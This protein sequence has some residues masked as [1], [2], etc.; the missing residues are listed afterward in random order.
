MHVGVHKQYCQHISLYVLQRTRK[1]L[2][3][4]TSQLS[5]SLKDP[6]EDTRTSSQSLPSPG[7]F[8]WWR[9]SNFMTA[10]C[11]DASTSFVSVRTSLLRNTFTHTL[12]PFEAIMRTKTDLVNTEITLLSIINYAPGSII[13][14]KNSSLQI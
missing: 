12:F 5:S 11:L 7:Y 1:S 10:I 4:K 13:I 3:R 6:P 2:S 9:I 14:K 8:K